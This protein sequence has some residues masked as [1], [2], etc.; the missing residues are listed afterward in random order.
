MGSIKR[1]DNKIK[2]DRYFKL[3]AGFI[4]LFSSPGDVD[5]LNNLI[6]DKNDKGKIHERQP[7]LLLIVC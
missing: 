3:P 4:T 6:K 2:T 1:Q 7:D 5:F